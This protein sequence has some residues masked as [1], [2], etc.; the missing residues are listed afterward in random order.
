M[1][2][3]AEGEGRSGGGCSP[4]SGKYSEHRSC[5]PANPGM[6]RG[7]ALKVG[8]ARFSTAAAAAAAVAAAAVAAWLPRYL[9]YRE[10]A[11]HE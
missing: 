2:D 1:A 5:S 10:P 6:R 4:V 9:R 7:A 11:A 8:A 3:G